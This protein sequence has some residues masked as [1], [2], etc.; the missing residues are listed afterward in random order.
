[1]LAGMLISLQT[2]HATQLPDMVNPGASGQQQGKAAIYSLKQVMRIF[3]C[4][5]QQISGLDG[6]LWTVGRSGRQW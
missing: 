6:R 4:T 3:A 1:M 5:F 2:T